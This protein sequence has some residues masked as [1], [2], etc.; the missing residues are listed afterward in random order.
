MFGFSISILS[1]LLWPVLP[2][3][4][5]YMASVVVGL[6]VLKRTPV[7]AGA[8]LAVGWFS[9]FVQLLLVDEPPNS[10]QNIIVRGEIIAL[11]ASNG[12][13]LSMDIRQSNLKSAFILSK[14]LRLS[15]KQAPKLAIGEQWEWVIKPKPI[16]SVLNQGGYNQQRSFLS[17]HIVMKGSVKSG[18]KLKEA[19]SLR[20]KIVKKLKPELAHF[21]HGDLMLALLLGDKSLIDSERWR[22]L[23]VSGSGHLIA[24]SGLHLSVVTTWVFFLSLFLLT[25]FKPSLSRKNILIAGLFSAVA[26]IFYAYLAGFSLPTQ[27][28]LIMLLLLLTMGLMKRFSS[29]WER[30]L[31]ALFFILLFDP[32]AC[33]S[34]GFWLSFSALG[35]IFLSLSQWT[36]R[37]SAQEAD[38]GPLLNVKNKLAMF[39]SVQWRLSLGLGL[40]QAL[41]FGGISAY[42]LLFNLVLVPW[43][44]LVVIPVSFLCFLIW[45]GGHVLFMELPQI[46]TL[47]DL[48]LMPMSLGFGLIE[49]LPGAWISVSGQTIAC[50]IFF[51]LGLLMFRLSQQ[52]WRLVSISLCMPLVLSVVFGLVTPPQDEWRLHLLDVGQG[53]SAVIEKSGKA[54]IYDTGAAYG[55]NFSYAERVILPFLRFRGLDS[56]DYLVLSHSDNDHAGGAKLLVESFPDARVITDMPEY[57]Q[58]NCRPKSLLWQGL[59]LEILAPMIPEDGNNGSCVLRVSDGKHQLMLSGDI[60]KEAE[61][62]LLDSQQTL[63]SE[64]L[65]VPHHGSRTSSTAA[66]INRVSPQLVLFPAGFNNRYGFPKKD[67]VERYLSTG[68]QVLVTGSEGQISVLFHHDERRASTYRGDLAPFW[69]NSLF[70]FGEN[71]NTE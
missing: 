30:L 63:L 56:V 3:T 27:R 58:L 55:T 25:R 20:S 60:E 42:G 39:W 67:V 65:V 37:E 50:L 19:Q 2:S 61:V 8:L 17:R 44:S 29:P 31:Y 24:I 66:F 7:I 33:M 62:L 10:V 36:R 51:M 38:T 9:L 32:L 1:S 22:S 34:A 14:V 23:R 52:R 46:F 15:W 59:K 11:V 48:S 16:T 26:A 12:D 41:L 18:I 5:V 28:A 35:I 13:W 70:R 45:A 49:S 47:V 21:A 40:I 64:V 71:N 4:P 43:F 69:Y 6:I 54:L 68:A 53:L 57:S